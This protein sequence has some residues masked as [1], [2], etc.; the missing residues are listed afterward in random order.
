MLKGNIDP[1]FSQKPDLTNFVANGENLLDRVQAD[2]GWFERIAVEESFLQG[3][4]RR[5]NTLQHL[6][7]QS[8]WHAWWGDN[9][10][11]GFTEIKL[12]NTR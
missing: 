1:R 3:A 11:C 5:V 10:K 12:E 4:V 2:A 7:L 6:G 9:K 8:V